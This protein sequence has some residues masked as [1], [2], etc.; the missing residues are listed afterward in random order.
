[1]WHLQEEETALTPFSGLRSVPIAEFHKCKPSGGLRIPHFTYFTRITGQNQRI[2]HIFQA[3]PCP[4][5]PA[6]LRPSPIEGQDTGEQYHDAQH[7]AACHGI[8]RTRWLPLPWA[9]PKTKPIGGGY[10]VEVKFRGGEA[11]P[12]RVDLC[13]FDDPMNVSLAV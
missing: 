3:F 2:P 11:A 5:V 12:V 9:Q 13:G 8:Y 7:T 1:L 4:S 6:E 10:H